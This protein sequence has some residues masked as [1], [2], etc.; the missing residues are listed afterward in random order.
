MI[1]NEMMMLGERPWRIQIEHK[2]MSNGNQIN[3]SQL[4][5]H[6]RIDSSAL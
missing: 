3:P 5:R 6:M 2:K 4:N 1:M